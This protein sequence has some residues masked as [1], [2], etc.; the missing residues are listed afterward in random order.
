MKQNEL[1]KQWAEVN[2]SVMESMKQLG[3]IN[4]SVMTK[5]NER[6]M[7]AI[8]AYMEGVS[9]Q[10]ES[11]GE[12][13][14]AQDVIAVQSKLAK[15]FSEKLLENAR[16]TMDV[17]MQTRTDLAGWVEKGMEAANKAVKKD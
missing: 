16:Q 15:D 10:M 8:N 13:K 4:S 3:E 7:A 6:Q 17:L 11:M 1:M 14:N 5:L 9:K 12:A 2:K